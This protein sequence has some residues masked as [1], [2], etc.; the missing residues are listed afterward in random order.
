METRKEMGKLGNDLI[1]MRKQNAR[2]AIGKTENPVYI[3]K[4]SSQFAP[5]VYYKGA[6]KNGRIG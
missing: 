1:D 2:L 5:Q 4:S 3:S 6:A